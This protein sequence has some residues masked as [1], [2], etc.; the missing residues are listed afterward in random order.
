MQAPTTFGR[1]TL[2]CASEYT[3]TDGVPA[4]ATCRSTATLLP[5]RPISLPGYVARQ[6]CG[7]TLSSGA[8]ASACASTDG[9]AGRA[10]RARRRAYQSRQQSIHATA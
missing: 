7:G 5:P 3:C 2:R 1:G 4:R 10:G 9:S 6:R 8:W